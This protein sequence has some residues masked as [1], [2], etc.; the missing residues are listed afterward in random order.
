ML[1]WLQC[2]RRLDLPHLEFNSFTVLLAQIGAVLVASRL[3]GVVARWLG[4]PLVIAEM[5]AGIALGPS[6][7]GGLWPQGAH[8]LF[9]SE[10]LPVLKALSQ[11]GLLLF[12]FLVGLELDPK[13]LRGRACSS[14]AIS[15]ASI[16]LPFAL[17]AGAA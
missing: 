8:W 14:F 11:V 5:A 6:V 1:A 15:H 13:I 17:G 10:S 16:L 2:H 7:L 9:P 3:L 12:M 4:Q